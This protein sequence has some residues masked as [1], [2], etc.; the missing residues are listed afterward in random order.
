[1][2]N[3]GVGAGGW[4]EFGCIFLSYLKL[5]CDLF[6]AESG[7][8]VLCCVVL[9]CVVSPAINGMDGIGVTWRGR[10]DSLICRSSDLCYSHHGLRGVVL[11]RGIYG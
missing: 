1:M 7:G 11:R 8:I 5:L 9:C 4:G 2:L 10:G 6:A 3:N